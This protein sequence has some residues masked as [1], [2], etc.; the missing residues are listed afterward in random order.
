MWTV[1]DRASLLKK[2]EDPTKDCVPLPNITHSLGSPALLPYRMVAPGGE[3][4]VY[5]PHTSRKMYVL[6]DSLAWHPVK[7]CKIESKKGGWNPMKNLLLSMPPLADCKC[8]LSWQCAYVHTY[9]C[10]WWWF[11]IMTRDQQRVQEGNFTQEGQIKSVPVHTYS[12]PLMI[13]RHSEPSWHFS[14]SASLSTISGHG[15]QIWEWATSPEVQ[16][17]ASLSYTCCLSKVQPDAKVLREWDIYLTEEILGHYL[18]RSL[19]RSYHSSL[20]FQTTQ[21][22]LKSASYGSPV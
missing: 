22:A 12:L 2:K 17:S 3:S 4:A 1:V 10:M 8:H 9:M 20:S 14:G 11:E 5:W 7:K 6:G 19:D 18:K 15:L 16:Y 21:E 13:G